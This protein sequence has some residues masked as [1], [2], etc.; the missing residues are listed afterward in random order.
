MTW[1]EKNSCYQSIVLYFY[2]VSCLLG[3]WQDIEEKYYADKEDAY[4]MRKTWLGV[5]RF[6]V[7]MMVPK[8]IH[9]CFV[10]EFYIL[11]SKA[12]S[13][14]C[15]AGAGERWRGRHI[16]GIEGMKHLPFQPMTSTDLTDLSIP[17]DL[18][19]WG[20]VVGSTMFHSQ[21]RRNWKK[22]SKKKRRPW[23]PREL[24]A[25][26]GVA[27]GTWKWVLILGGSRLKKKL[28]ARAHNWL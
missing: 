18:S 7:Q 9:S 3:S 20:N 15:Q 1:G 11:C 26:L 19:V 21:G 23:K 25:Q 13:R 6:S 14:L 24:L 12:Q 16:L 5:C 4:D 8:N 28:A 17:S 22:R 27:S 10:L 2:W